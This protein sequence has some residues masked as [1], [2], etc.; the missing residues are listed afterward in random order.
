M[1]G[2]TYKYLKKLNIYGNWKILFIG[3]L[4]KTV[5]RSCKYYNRIG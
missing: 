2:A 1:D 5:E 3:Q 4:K